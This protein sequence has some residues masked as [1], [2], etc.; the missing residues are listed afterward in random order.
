MEDLFSV[1]DAGVLD[2]EIEEK[3]AEDLRHRANDAFEEFREGDTEKALDELADL[4]EKVGEAVEHEEVAHSQEQKLVK[5]IEDVAEQ[6][7]RAAPPDD[8]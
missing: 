3:A 7:L 5:A 2:G 1:V 6:M 8:D 4:R